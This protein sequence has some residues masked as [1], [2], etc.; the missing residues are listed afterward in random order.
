M[1]QNKK[2]IADQPMTNNHTCKIINSLEEFIRLCVLDNEISQNWI[3][4]VI[5]WRKIIEFARQKED[6]SDLQIENF[7]VLCDDF[8]QN[9]WH[10]IKKMMWAIMYTLLELATLN[11]I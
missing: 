6:F 2:T 1:L 7:Q 8:F 4:Y 3:E 10:S 5:L 11:I 9:G